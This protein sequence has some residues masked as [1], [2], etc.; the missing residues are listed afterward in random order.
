MRDPTK[1]AAEANLWLAL[2]LSLLL[3]AL[4]ATFRVRL[5]NLSLAPETLSIL[6][7]LQ[8][9]H[10]L[11]E[12]P[13]DS[14]LL[15]LA[16]HL[17]QAI[18]DTQHFTRRCI[19]AFWL[20]GCSYLLIALLVAALASPLLQLLT[21]HGQDTWQARHYLRLE[22]LGQLP[23]A[24]LGVVQG[25]A[26]AL[27]RGLWLYALGI[28]QLLLNVACDALLLPLAGTG[29]A[30]LLLAAIAPSLA[31]S[32]LLLCCW[33]LVRAHAM[34]RWQWPSTDGLR[35]W[36]RRS[37]I[38]AVECVLRNVVFALLVLRLVNLS[39]HATLFWNTNTFLW[40]WL[41]LPVLALGVLVRRNAAN[42]R[43][44]RF[45]DPVHYLLAIGLIGVLWL[46]SHPWWETFIALALGY[47]QAPAA[48][49]LAWSQM[50][51]YLA[52]AFGFLLNQHFAGKGRSGVLLLQSAIINIVYYGL[53]WLGLQAGWWH[54]SLENITRL[55][56]GSMLA[57]LCVLLLQYGLDLKEKS[58]ARPLPAG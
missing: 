8:W 22:A 55:F 2:L 43:G 6:A 20:V 51:C 16:F 14:L 49:A 7:Q 58:S 39:G 18:E 21:T 5:L 42:Q 50:P 40:N 29:G 35:L 41:L 32:L 10:L 23:V 26:L 27:G 12:I 4:Y 47:A 56:G 52:F 46:A 3:P 30:S 17:G 38:A 37:G 15:L 54:P 44:R 33:W 1:P 34:V 25:I 36:L 48:A 13:R 24:L 45:T 57:G 9:L 53:A 11:L 28:S 31:A 19:N